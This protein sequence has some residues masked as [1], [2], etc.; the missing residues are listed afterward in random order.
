MVIISQALCLFNKTIYDLYYKKRENF[1]TVEK[2]GEYSLY[3]W[4][5]IEMLYMQGTY[6]ETPRVSV[7]LV[8][9]TIDSAGM[10][11]S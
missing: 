4:K 9:M 3:I 7:T 2:I 5:I 11:N 8:T 10:N 1:R 6:G